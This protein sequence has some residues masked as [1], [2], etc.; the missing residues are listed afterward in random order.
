MRCLAYKIYDRI[1]STWLISRIFYDGI[2]YQHFGAISITGVMAD[3]VHSSSDGD[4]TFD[5][6]AQ[7]VHPEKW[8]CELT[9]CQSKALHELAKMLKPGMRVKI[10]G[11]STYDPTHLGIPGHWEVHP[12]TNIVILGS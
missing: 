5:V 8:H 12:V 1:K 6:N 9:P 3:C 7:G 4:N 2:K 11:T 10:S